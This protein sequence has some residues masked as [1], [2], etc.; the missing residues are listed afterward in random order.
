MATLYCKCKG[1]HKLWAEFWWDADIDKHHWV[2]LDDNKQSDTYK[3]KLNRCPACD[4]ELHR[5]V[6]VTA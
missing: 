4:T 6:L 1:H 2:F 3:Q 5:K